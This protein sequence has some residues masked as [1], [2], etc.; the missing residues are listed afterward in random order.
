MV[1]HQYTRLLF[2]EVINVFLPA[3]EGHQGKSQSVVHLT[4]VFADDQGEA[5]CLQVWCSWDAEAT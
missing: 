4:Q 2:V 1:S 3:V 5:S